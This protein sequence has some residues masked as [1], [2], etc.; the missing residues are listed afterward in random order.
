MPLKHGNSPGIISQNIREMINAGHPRK[1]AVAAALRT[2][3]EMA[4]GG[5]IPHAGPLNYAIGGRTDQIPLNVKK[6]SYVI[7]ADVVSGLGQGNTLNGTKVLNNLFKTG[8]YGT[9][10]P[11]MG[12]KSSIP[13]PPRIAKPQPL[14]YA[15]GGAVPIMAAGGEYVLTPEEV[16]QVGGGDLQHGFDVLDEFVKHVRDQNI[17][18]LKKLPGPAKK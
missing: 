10:L 1:Q 2:A 12:G 5:R 4:A 17:K 8:P 11:R 6:G 14:G 7:P 18:T 13:R 16:A 15:D 9:P 3:R